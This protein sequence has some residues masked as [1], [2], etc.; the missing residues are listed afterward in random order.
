MDP[1]TSIVPSNS[2]NSL[3]KSSG[4]LSFIILVFGLVKDRIFNEVNKK[5]LNQLRLIYSI[6]QKK[7][8]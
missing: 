2:P 6:K 7:A 1:T 5:S 4:L 3:L 8:L